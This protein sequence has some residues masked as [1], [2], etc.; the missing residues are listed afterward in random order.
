M[1]SWNSAA[2][3]NLDTS[4]YLSCFL[5]CCANVIQGK[6]LFHKIVKS[7]SSFTD[8]YNSFVCK[9]NTPV[10]S[11]SVFATTAHCLLALWL[12]LFLL[13]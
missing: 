4:L 1:S 7:L 8:Y 6:Y 2:L 13:Y 11:V 3:D 9:G 5:I 10:V 12:S